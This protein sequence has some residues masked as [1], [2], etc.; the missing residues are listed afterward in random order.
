[1]EPDKGKETEENL[2]KRNIRRKTLTGIVVSDRMDKTVVV[3]VDRL[4][5]H[6]AYKKYIHRKK[7]YMVHD[8]GNQCKIGDKVLIIESRPLSRHKRWRVMKTIEKAV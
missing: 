4:V 1:M 5:Q 8:E 2:K 3:E 7:K 6:P